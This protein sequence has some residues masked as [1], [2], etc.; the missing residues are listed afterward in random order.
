MDALAGGAANETPAPPGIGSSRRYDRSAGTESSLPASQFSESG[1]VK[2]ASGKAESSPSLGSDGKS[3][4]EKQHGVIE[5][6][7]L[8]DRGEGF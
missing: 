2:N 1:A 6:V 3:V 5:E 4:G 8:S 7:N